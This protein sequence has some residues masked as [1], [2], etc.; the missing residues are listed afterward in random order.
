MSS[1]YVSDQRPEPVTAVIPAYNEEAY[2]GETLEILRSV[3]SLT[4]ILV[5]DDC[6]TDE[7]VAI[8]QAQ[9]DVDQR[10]RLLTLPTNQGKGD[11]VLAGANASHND[12]TVLLDADLIGLRPQNVLDLIEPVRSFRY[13]MTLGIFTHGRLQTDWSHRLTPFLSGQRCLRW[14]LF[15][16]TPGMEGARWGIEVALSLH[17]WRHQFGVLRVPWSG[18]THA[19]RMEKVKGLDSYVSHLVM[20]YDIS[21][22]VI[23][24]FRLEKPP[25]FRSIRRAASMHRLSSAFKFGRKNKQFPGD[26]P[27]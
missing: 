9:S 5:V 2:I 18:V 10:V 4:Q 16:D 22:Y 24:H 26:V 13:G 7:T 17:A 23:R 3:E 14:S 6:S 12:L 1:I 21:K 25:K 19:M 20:W 11:A 27:Q 8:V 15:R